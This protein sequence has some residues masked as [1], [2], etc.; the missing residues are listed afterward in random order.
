MPLQLLILDAAEYEFGW[1]EVAA[2]YKVYACHRAQLDILASRR[3]FTAA[4]FGTGSGKTALIPLWIFQRIA[5]LRKH[6]VTRLL[7]FLIVSP[8]LPSFESSQLKQHLLS[9]F[10]DTSYSGGW[11]DQKKVYFG[12]GFEI[13]VRTAEDDYQRISGGQFDGIVFD[14]AWQIKNVQVWEEG[15]RRSNIFEAPIL[16]VTTPNVDGWLRSKIM[17]PFL[18]GDP[19]FYVR[20]ESTRA[21]P[22]KTPEQHHRFLESELIKLGQAKFDRMYGGLFAELTGLVYPAMGLKETDPNYPVIP[23]GPLPS[24][25]VSCFGGVDWGYHPDPF[26]GHMLIRCDNGIIYCVDEIYGRKIQTDM[27]GRM[28]RDWQDKWSLSADSQ[29][30]V[31]GGFFER[32]YCD[33]S[34]PESRDMV[35]RFGVSIGNRK[36]ADIDAGISVVD[37]M[38]N[39]GRLKIMDNCKG[40]ITELQNYSWHE[41]PNGEIRPKGH[42]GDHAAD[43]FRYAVSSHM[44]GRPITLLPDEAKPADQVEN[45]IRLGQVASKEEAAAI[46]ATKERDRVLQHQ[47]DMM[48]ADD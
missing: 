35:R 23:A 6:G 43:N 41:R 14:E 7:R 29:Y 27:V 19:D 28:L 22:A 47:L 34:R 46:V 12:P 36:V 20:Q 44:Q 13:V 16:L 17:V 30:S 21:N 1:G 11:L 15:I 5:E 10:A 2:G 39:V 4:F 24:P 9:T 3:K 31:H 42:A 25:A 45:A 37:Q 32:Y 40:L 26:A 38:F 8:N 48:N 33:S 18:Q